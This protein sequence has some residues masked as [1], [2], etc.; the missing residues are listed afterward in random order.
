VIKD[1]ELD[2][3]AATQAAEAWKA[4]AAPGIT[5]P[6]RDD[7]AL[8]DPVVRAPQAEDLPVARVVK[9]DSPPPKEQSD[10]MPLARLV[11]A[12]L[13]Q[14][15]DGSINAALAIE[16]DWREGGGTESFTGASELVRAQ[17]PL[18]RE[19]VGVASELPAPVVQ[20]LATGIAAGEAAT[21]RPALDAFRKTD[22]NAANAAN[23]LLAVR[24]KR[25]YDASGGALYTAPPA[26]PDY[27]AN[28][29][30]P[31]KV[32]RSSG[33]TG[34][35]IVSICAVAISGILRIASQSHS[36]YDYHPIDIPNIDPSLYNLPPLPP[37]YDPNLYNTYTP[38][39]STPT[40]PSAMSAD[41]D[42]SVLLDEIVVE[43]QNLTTY[44]LVPEAGQAKV[45]TFM[46]DVLDDAC[47]RMRVSFPKVEKLKA[48]DDA[49][50]AASA[51]EQLTAIRQR[52]DVVC[53]KHHTGKSK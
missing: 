1:D 22:A 32:T 46:G 9:M 24:A 2:E 35:R 50:K 16:E 45:D 31:P 29:I 21:A 30:P 12:L 51:K 26:R 20:A 33:F 3:V 48:I 14:L 4:D 42:R 8:W 49:E 19:L 10:A 47:A 15:E 34:W 18:V 11:P 25:L 6:E 53:P 37:S 17:W 39:A 5:K 27:Y 40:S 7:S 28:Y 23:G 36:S 44:G 41:E 43:T 38:P 52:L 13:Q